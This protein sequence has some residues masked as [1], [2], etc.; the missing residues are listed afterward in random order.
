M[1]GSEAQ[2]TGPQRSGSTPS[3]AREVFSRLSLSPNFTH[4]RHS[5]DMLPAELNDRLASGPESFRK[6]PASNLEVTYDAW[7]NL[8][9]RTP[10]PP[11]YCDAVARLSSGLAVRLPHVR[12]PVRKQ[13]GSHAD[14]LGPRSDLFKGSRLVLVEDDPLRHLHSAASVSPPDAAF[15]GRS[16][17]PDL[18][19]S[20]RTAIA[21]G[22]ALPS[23][24]ERQQRL[25]SAVA[26]DIEPLNKW[27]VTSVVR[28]EPALKVASNVHVALICAMTDAMDWP[29]KA[30]GNGFLRG[31][32]VLG[33]IPDTGVFRPLIPGSPP[34]D[35]PARHA[36]IIADN[37]RWNLSLSTNLRR[38]FNSA[39]TGPSAQRATKLQKAL[40]VATLKEV[41]GGLMSPAL[42]KEDLDN[43]FGV[44]GWRA[45]GRFAV[46]QNGKVRPVDDGSASRH[47]EATFTSETISLPSFE[48]PALVSS[49]VIEVCD[50]LGVD[51]VPFLLALDD[52]DSAYRRVPT[53]EPQFTVCAYF[54]PSKKRVVFHKV[55]G[56]NFGLVSSV[57]NFSR[58]PALFT[59]FLRRFFLCWVDHYVDD[60]LEVDV[61][62]AV[63]A[64]AQ[65]YVHVLHNAARFFLSDK[66]RV[67][68]APVNR[69]L[70]VICDLSK[71]HSA[72]RVA[73][74]SPRPGRCEDLL[75]MLDRIRRHNGLSAP[76]AKRL[77]GLLGFLL[78]STYGRVGRAAS[79]SFIMAS[80]AEGWSPLSVALRET[81][82]FFEILLPK[83]PPREISLRP[84]PSYPK[85]VVYSDASEDSKYCGIGFVVL[86]YLGPG[87]SP[88]GVFFGS[89]VCPAWILQRM[90]NVASRA[91][92]QLEILAAIVVHLS[93][94]Q[95]LR[96]VTKLHFIDNTAAM[97]A[98]VHGYSSK[99]DMARLS[100][101]YHLLTF[102]SRSF[103]WFEWVPSKANLADAPSRPRF[104]KGTDQWASLMILGARRVPIV[105]PTQS[106]WDHL[107]FYL[108]A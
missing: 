72:D 91:I 94:P 100:N 67:A 47:N 5:E 71:A 9:L 46:Q 89:D 34:D 26:K 101:I 38:S 76:F 20:I 59:A 102:E 98:L 60:F 108:P 92:C 3:A 22:D 25:L 87:Q 17:P 21:M 103:S 80:N 57:L 6:S 85:V 106:Q 32:P 83:L 74:F 64:H 52:V 8:G 51:P 39:A 29:D 12:P 95:I 35:F 63:D 16:L 93:C 28:A 14:P 4:C 96:N 15:C 68:P 37:D 65:I 48:F 97:S 42:S 23:W 13:K 43:E 40:E 31:M 44:G 99:V 69:E 56:H 53:S 2:P 75:S 61:V 55:Y 49:Y 90:Y 79:Q 78:S 10:P 104:D 105:F 7:N 58:V 24:R 41:D 1:A 54:S 82:R 45:I 77:C 18:K 107:D 33:A 30:I 36:S 11:E 88:A 84:R 66:K 70:G 50:E 81:I 19:A 73:V 86:V 27:L 62:R